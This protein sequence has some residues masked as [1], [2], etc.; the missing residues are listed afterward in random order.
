MIPNLTHH[1]SSSF[2]GQLLAK[3]RYHHN[4]DAR[5]VGG[6]VRDTLL[7]KTVTDWD[8]V[9]PTLPENL[10]NAIQNI[11]GVDGRIQ[12]I[13]L[14]YGVVSTKWHRHHIT[15]AACRKDIASIGQR[16]TT[17]E[18]S[19]DWEAD[20]ARRDFTCNAVYF[21]GNQLWDPFGGLEDIQQRLVRF[22]GAP[23]ERINQDILRFWRFFRFWAHM[24]H[25]QNIDLSQHVANLKHLS[26]ERTAQELRMLMKGEHC[27]SALQELR[28]IGALSNTLEDVIS[29]CQH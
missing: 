22:I 15:M 21:D 1:L 20:A 28:R 29:A 3:I 23:H 16:Y 27:T 2:G 10:Q 7:G 13:G 26:F 14:K 4:W 9:V 24:G 25:G 8:F 6:A 19:D 11:I 5:L 18:F 12:T 17:V